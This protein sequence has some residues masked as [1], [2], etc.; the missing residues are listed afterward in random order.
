MSLIKLQKAEPE[1]LSIYRVDQIIALAG[2]G[3]IKDGSTC[4]AEFR[5]FLR[6]QPASTLRRYVQE[7]LAGPFTDSGFA[8][9]DIVNE[10]GRRLGFSVVDGRY[11][12]VVKQSG[13]DGLW[14]TDEMNLVVEVKTT[15]AYR[16][17]LS[18]V[19]SYAKSVRT[20][21]QESVATLG[22]LYVVG[23]QD[24]GD[25]EAQI[26][27]SRYAWDVRV[28]SA[29]ALLDLADLVEVAV[30]DDTAKALRSSLLPVEYTRIDHLVQLLTMLAFD[31]ERSVQVSEALDDE[32]VTQVPTLCES[33]AKHPEKMASSSPDE[34]REI[35]VRSLRQN[36]NTEVVKLTKSSYATPQGMNY[37]I[38]VSKRYSRTDQNYWYAFQAKW[39][40]KLKKE[41]SFLCLAMLDR[42]YFFCIPGTKAIEFTSHLNKTVK[43]SGSYWHIGLTEESDRVLL[44]LPKA[45]KLVDLTEFKVHL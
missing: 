32:Q 28:I 15:D 14:L 27:G 6:T 29:E 36:L 43:S 45:A 39:A 24:T 33:V 11:R 21:L 16:I 7:T 35:V 10:I 8:L 30:D 20:D 19:A 34:F 3:R 42:E 18:T 22:I 1:A 31:V 2:D 38:S 37:V 44:S 23:R 5:E 9:Q 12:G 25:L 13:Q 17:N 26:R 40:E 4:S 41:D